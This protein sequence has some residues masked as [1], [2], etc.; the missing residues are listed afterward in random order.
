[1]VQFTDDGAE[2]ANRG[3]TV[4]I[5]LK[6]IGETAFSHQGKIDFVDNS[7]DRSSSTI[8]VRA[9]FANPRGRFTPGMFARLRM[10]AAPPK[11]ALLVPE[12]AV[13]AEQGR[14]FVFVVDA[15]NVARQKFVTLG[16]VADGLRV[17]TQG[18]TPDDNI[19]VNGLIRARPGTKVTPQQSSAASTSAAGIQIGTN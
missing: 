10:A 18:V 16:P 13:G 5:T 15:E 8:R 19:I 3:L 2:A 12:A 4:P 6:L 11:N 17:I 9:V 1:Y 7:I 14:K